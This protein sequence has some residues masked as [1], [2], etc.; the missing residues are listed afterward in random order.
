LK[1]FAY[2]SEQE[3]V[4]SGNDS[5]NREAVCR[6]FR[7]RHLS[8][9]FRVITREIIDRTGNATGQLETILVND[10]VPLMTLG[11]TGSILVPILT[12][13]V[14]CVVKVKTSLTIESLRKALSQMHPAKEL[15]PYMGL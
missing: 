1:A 7:A 3:L 6:L 11:M 15:M 2:A 10:D 5:H 13:T 8:P 9:G 4:V 14:L 12:D